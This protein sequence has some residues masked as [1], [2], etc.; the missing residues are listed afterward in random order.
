MLLCLCRQLFRTKLSVVLEISSNSERT[1]YE[2]NFMDCT[3]RI[4]IDTFC[5][6]TTDYLV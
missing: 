4:Y 3:F 6:L 1:V 2:K 5:F